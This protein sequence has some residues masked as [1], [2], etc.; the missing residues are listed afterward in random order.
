MILDDVRI[1]GRCLVGGKEKLD[2]R[3][4]RVREGGRGGSRRR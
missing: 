2:R 4:A 3:L 1:P